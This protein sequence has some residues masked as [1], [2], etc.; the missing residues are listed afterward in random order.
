MKRLLLI[1][2]GIVFCRMGVFAQDVT[3]EVHGIRYAKGNIL[4]MAQKDETSKPVYAMVKAAEGT[5]VVVLKD[6]L[7]E[8]FTL[9]LFH[10]ENENMDLDKDEQGRPLEGY[11]REKCK[12]E[13]DKPATVKVKLYYPI[14]K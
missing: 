9:S 10:D 2:L 6:V 11:A 5:A 14:Y 3:V 1:V 7:W 13:S 4:V 12:K 8:K